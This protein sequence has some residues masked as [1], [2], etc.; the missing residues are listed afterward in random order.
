M[1]R[2][3]LQVARRASV[4]DR[5]SIRLKRREGVVYKSVLID[6]DHL[7][8]DPGCLKRA[9]E[10]GIKRLRQQRQFRA[11]VGAAHPER[12]YA[13]ISHIRDDHVLCAGLQ[14]LPTMPA[15]C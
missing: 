15:S 9:R 3:Q 7:V 11:V 12:R 13:D 14:D 4:A 1:S 8:L 6:G 5:E 10:R 2:K